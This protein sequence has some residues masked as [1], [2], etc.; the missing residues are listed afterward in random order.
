VGGRLD[1]A[2][3]VVLQGLRPGGIEDGALAASG[4]CG[5]EFYGEVHRVCLAQGRHRF[6]LG[7]QPGSG[8]AKLRPREAATGHHDGG[9]VRPLVGPAL[10]VVEERHRINFTGGH[11]LKSGPAGIV[12]S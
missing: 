6:G 9:V 2:H 4:Y 1:P 10:D 8:I 12:T 5:G 3:N 7:D 11:R